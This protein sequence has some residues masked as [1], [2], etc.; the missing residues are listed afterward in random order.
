MTTVRGLCVLTCLTCVVA[1]G[2]T[3]NSSGTPTPGGK[4]GNPCL[5]ASAPVGCYSD[6]TGANMTVSCPA[7]VSPATWVA[8]TTCAAGTHCAIQGS[9]AACVANPV[10]TV[11]DTVGGKGDST[12]SSACVDAKCA[13]QTAACTASSACMTAL[14]CLSACNGSQTCQ[15]Q[16][17]APLQSNPTAATAFQN[18]L[19]CMINAAMSCSLGA[20]AGT[21]DIQLGDII[22]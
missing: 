8:G 14:S 18:L 10:T 15:D 19:Q 6:S 21:T 13:S 20:D 9:A 12:A 11:N 1:C 16:C 3:A 17:A 7:D 2:T 22:P 5:A 4:P